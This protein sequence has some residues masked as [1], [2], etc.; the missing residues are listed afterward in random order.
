MIDAF[1][2]LDFPKVHFFSSNTDHQHTFSINFDVSYSFFVLSNILSA[3]PVVDIPKANVAITLAIVSDT[4]NE[5][6]RN[7]AMVMHGHRQIFFSY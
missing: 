1:E 4:T 5:K 6:E 3:F 7:H 2:G